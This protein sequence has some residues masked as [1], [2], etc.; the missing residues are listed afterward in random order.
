[1]I[2]DISHI[3]K[4]YQQHGVYFLRWTPKVSYPKG[5]AARIFHKLA[6]L[7]AALEMK[8]ALCQAKKRGL[9]L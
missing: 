5:K 9:L 3:G 8:D 6:A 7:S 4:A 2:P 1:M